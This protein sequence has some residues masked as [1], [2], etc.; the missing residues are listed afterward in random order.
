MQIANIHTDQ[1]FGFPRGAFQ[2]KQRPFFKMFL[3]RIEQNFFFIQSLHRLPQHSMNRKIQNILAGP[4][5]EI[6]SPFKVRDDQT[7]LHASDNFF[8]K[9]FQIGK[10]FI[11]FL[12][13]GV[14]TFQALGKITAEKSNRVKSENVHEN[15]VVNQAAGNVRDFLCRQI[16][17][18][19]DFVIE[20]NDKRRIRKAADRSDVHASSAVEQDA[21]GDDR[22]DVEERERAFDAT[23]EVNQQRNHKNIARK[24]QIR[25]DF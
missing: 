6:D 25:E 19:N 24:L 21:S 22:Q 23:R 9:N 7:A 1:P 16:V 17:I 4:V 2:R 13:R 15:E 18:R 12:K 11:F 10:I 5:D 8:V 14:A 20:Q 3:H